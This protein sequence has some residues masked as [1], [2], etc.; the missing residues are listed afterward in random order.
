MLL[1]FCYNHRKFIKIPLQIQP[2]CPLF[3]PKNRFLWYFSIRLQEIRCPVPCPTEVRCP[4]LPYAYREVMPQPWDRDGMRCPM[5]RP[6]VRQKTQR[7]AWAYAARC[8]GECNALHGHMHRTAFSGAELRGFGCSG[9]REWVTGIANARGKA[10]PAPSSP[11][12]GMDQ[13]RDRAEKSVCTTSSAPL[14]QE[15]GNGE[16]R[17][18]A[19]PMASPVPLTQENGNGA[20]VGQASRPLPPARM[21]TQKGCVT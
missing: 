12:A 20:E 18:Q 13:S 7:A 19:S 11:S 21:K 15:N 10:S 1:F 5:T 17:K 3:L 4:I 9:Q 8:D 2:S 14:A 16:E 6:T